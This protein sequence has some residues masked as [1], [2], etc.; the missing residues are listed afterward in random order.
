[1]LNYNK[2]AFFCAKNLNLL[3]YVRLGEI[4]EI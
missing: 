4:Y 3:A 2:F 1:M